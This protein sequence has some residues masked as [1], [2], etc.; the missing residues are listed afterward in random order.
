MRI[1]KYISIILLLTVFFMSCSD[2]SCHLE[3]ESL[4]KTKI[5]ILDEDLIALKFL[6]SLSI[7]SPDWTDSIHFLDEGSDSSL[8]FML[9]PNSDSTE[10]IF[11]SKSH[12]NDTIVFFHRSEIV[13]LSP[14]CGFV[15]NFKIDS[16]SN[17]EHLIDSVSRKRDGITSNEKGLIEIY[18]F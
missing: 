14:E 13:F 6:D 18:Y 12:L 10:I 8:Y 2:D 9:S 3:T 16:I 7:Y 4:L 1:I 17:T 11:T 5:K 15:F